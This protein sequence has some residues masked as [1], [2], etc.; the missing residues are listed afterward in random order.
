MLQPNIVPIP[1]KDLT[2]VASTGVNTL[3]WNGDNGLSQA[4]FEIWRLNGDT[5]P[6]AI[7]ATTNEQTYEDTSVTPG[8][9]YIYKVRA[10]V[11]RAVS[12]FSNDAVVYGAN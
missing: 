7:L 12:E 10:L 11:R 4:I 9:Y 2:A 3:T 8:E 5:A 6:F 1:P